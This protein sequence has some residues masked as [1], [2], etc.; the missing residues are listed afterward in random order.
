[1]HYTKDGS[2]SAERLDVNHFITA[3][4]LFNFITKVMGR[5]FNRGTSLLS[6]IN[7]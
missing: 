7:F 3:D 1:L 6:F 5:G 2:S 4:S